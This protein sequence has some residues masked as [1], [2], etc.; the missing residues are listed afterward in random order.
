[1]QEQ[2]FKKRYL[3]VLSG[4][5]AAAELASA[6]AW[7]LLLLLA[8]RHE[9]VIAAMM[10]IARFTPAAVLP[11]P[12]PQQTQQTPGNIPSSPRTKP[13]RSPVASARPPPH[14]HGLTLLAIEMTWLDESQADGPVRSG[15]VVMVACFL[16]MLACNLA[17]WISTQRQVRP[18]STK[19]KSPPGL[20]QPARAA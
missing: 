12:L 6:R 7:R 13:Q 1:M 3:I 17:S 4:I 8:T 2:V 11:C 5:A 19:A 20:S 10:Y 9:Y 18:P 15:G 14:R 16:A